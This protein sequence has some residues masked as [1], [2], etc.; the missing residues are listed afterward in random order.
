MRLLLK[1]LKWCGIGLVAIL[2]C[3]AVYQAVG[4]ALDSRY[5]PPPSEMVAVNGHSVHVV[6]TGSG[7]HTFVLDAGLTAWSFEWFRVQP[8][9]ARHGRVCAFDRPGM[10]ASESANIDHDGLAAAAEV[11]AIVAAAK[12]PTPFIYVGHS[13]GANFAQIYDG[14]YPHEVAGLVLI[15]PGEP[16]DLLEDFHGT[17]AEAM[18]DS[19]CHVL[20][21]L[22]S[23]A[24]YLGVTRAAINLAHG[25]SKSWPPE[26]TLRYR[27]GAASPRAAATTL[28]EYVALPKT[29]YE[30][31]D[32]KSFGDTPVLIF[33]STLSRAPEGKETVADV[34][35]WKKG[36]LA[37]FAGLAARSTHGVGP[38][39]VPN[40]NHG[41][42]V[43]GVPQAAFV[44]RTII[45]FADGKL[46]AA[47]R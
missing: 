41:S 47:R 2:L 17:R 13:L 8:L 43:F 46:A 40:S 32:V 21:A 26:M 34:R 44:A 42:M 15:E 29:A 28:A 45:E 14:A 30:N 6:C 4:T 19:R 39:H 9:L 31:L 25:G 27:A 16:R 11:H 10:G 24:S 3:G 35:V 23:A 22:A 36:Q 5:D 20:C 38:I 37:F 7:T 33:D 18:A 12:I 1:I